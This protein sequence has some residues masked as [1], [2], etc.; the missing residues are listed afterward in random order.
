MTA[1][2]ADSARH[3]SGALQILRRTSDER[4]SQFLRYFECAYSSRSA[5][6]GSTRVARCA[7]IR[8]AI[9]VTASSTTA[10]I[11][12]VTVSRAVTPNSSD[13]SS[14]A[15]NSAPIDAD[16]DADQARAHFLA[17]HQR[18]HA[19]RVGAE[20]HADAELVRAL[21]HR[22]RR[23]AEHADRRHQQRQRRKTNQQH[24]R[25]TLVADRRPRSLRP[26]S[27]C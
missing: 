1:I 4:P 19:R 2:Q 8:H 20:R 3:G 9:I 22:V 21:R 13:S 5:V 16:G 7:G 12:S 17:Q 15:M 27:G 14:D 10:A 6:T 11:D 18:Q 26:S 23:H 25:Q 24:H